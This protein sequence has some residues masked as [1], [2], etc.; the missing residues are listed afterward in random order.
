MTDFDIFSGGFGEEVAANQKAAQVERELSAELKREEAEAEAAA[1]A[2]PIPSR[3]ILK[4]LGTVLVFQQLAGLSVPFGVSAWKGSP[5]QPFEGDCF[6]AGSR[7]FTEVAR[8]LQTAVPRS[9]QGTAADGY[10]D[11]IATLVTQ[12]QTIARLDL[13]MQRLVKDHAERIRKTQMGVGIEQ[14]ILIG[15][16]PVVRFLESNPKTFCAA[17]A[18]ARVAAVAGVGA[19]VGLLGWCL[20]TSVQTQQA[21]EGLGYR[22]VITAAKKVID[23]RKTAKVPA[24]QSRASVASGHAPVFPTMAGPSAMSD[25]P[26]VASSAGSASGLAPQP[27]P[28]HDSTGAGER[29]EADA[30]QVVPTPDQAAP[31]APVAPMPSVAQVR[32]PAGQTANLTGGVGSRSSRVNPQGQQAEAEETVRA[33]DSEDLEDLGAVAGT[34]GAERAPVDVAAGRAEQAPTPAPER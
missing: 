30:P 6:G 16:Y 2:L 10:A 34:Q 25:T 28:R 7:N 22:D 21:A 18:T 11:D 26:S 17:L 23:T 20:G 19:A 13:D 8:L 31:S 4:A 5:N 12:A 33:G 32:Q 1:A 29:S 24:P 3:I 27:A 15:T 9:W 14:D